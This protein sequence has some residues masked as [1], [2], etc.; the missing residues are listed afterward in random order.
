MIINLGVGFP[1]RCFQRLSIPDIAALRCRWHDS[2]QTRGQFNSVLSSYSFPHRWE[3]RLYLHPSTQFR[4]A[5][6]SL[7]M[8]AYYIYVPVSSFSR[9]N[10]PDTHTSASV[11]RAQKQVVT[12][13]NLKSEATQVVF[14]FSWWRNFLSES[15]GQDQQV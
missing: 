6:C 7:G 4:F 11:H 3:Y 10:F 9:E 13:S 8:L 15:P 5:K 12:G 1:L 14:S 2:R